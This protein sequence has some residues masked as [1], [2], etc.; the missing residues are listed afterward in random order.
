MLSVYC[1][2]SVELESR[3]RREGQWTLGWG[4]K[5]TFAWAAGM[6]AGV[7]GNKRREKRRTQRTALWLYPTVVTWPLSSTLGLVRSQRDTDHIRG[8]LGHQVHANVLWGLHCILKPSGHRTHRYYWTPREALPEKLPP[9]RF[10]LRQGCEWSL[11]QEKS[12]RS[13]ELSWDTP[14]ILELSQWNWGVV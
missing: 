9:S 1:G 12:R 11:S 5:W 4:E 2:L 6:I 8:T 7:G 10:L 3:S 13:R 14:G